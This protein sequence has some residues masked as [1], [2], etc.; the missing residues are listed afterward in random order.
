MGEDYYWFGENRNPNGTFFAVS[1]Y[2][3]RYLKQWEFRH[4]VLSMSSDPELDPAN[5]ERP[6]V[7]Y[8]E[9]TGRYVMW[10]HWEN[11]RDYGE[12]RAAVASSETVEG[13]YAYHGSFR[14]FAGTGVIDHDRPGYMSRDCTLFVDDDGTGYFLSTTNENYDVN[15]YRLTD[16]Y[17]DIDSRA[18]TLFAGG[19][20]EAPALFKRNG[21]YFLVTSG[22]TGWTP[23]QAQYA[24]STS[25]T[26][27]WS[28]M[29]NV[30]DSSTFYS[31]STFVVEVTGGGQ[32]SYLFMGDRWAGAYGGPV[33]ESSYVWQPIAFGAD[34]RM[35]MSWNNTLDIDA[36]QGRVI[37]S[38]ERFVLINRQSGLALDVEGGSSADGADLVQV[39]PSGAES[40]RWSLNY[41]E[42]GHFRLT[43]VMSGKVVDVPDES[44]EDGVELIQYED[45]NG[46][47]QGWRLIDLG[48]G[49]YR[50]VNQNSQ[51]FMG[52]VA[53][54]VVE[55]AAIEQRSETGGDEQTWIVTVAPSG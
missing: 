31:Q 46:D 27:G 7:V 18:A 52:V 3:S 41:N 40:Q 23:N 16:D 17:L 6:K 36:T 44:T 50:I 37:G 51:K 30:A 1:A 11:G 13:D 35:S 19:H 24:T 14:P 25:L 22:S 45:L 55:G 49:E 5:V 10:M 20:R 15:L 29:T 26:G 42:R 4:H 12:A 32:T 2:R 21:V 38:V 47:N 8:N 9:A 28:S 54:S 48:D 53:G 34:D 43:N 33:N 39:V